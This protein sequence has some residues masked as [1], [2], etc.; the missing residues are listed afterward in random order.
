M[1]HAVLIVISTIITIIALFLIFI[2]IKSKN[3]RT[4]FYNFLFN[5]IFT[6]S[7]A[8]NNIIRLI[9][10]S[11]TSQVEASG[12]CK[13][14]A[15]ILTVL[16]KL[17]MIL[18]TDYSIISFLGMFKF[19]YYSANTKW[20]F[21]ILVSISSL[22][23]IILAI[24]FINIDVIDPKDEF[25]YVNTRN[26]VKI[27]VDSV[28][29]GLL[30]LI[31]LFCLVRI[32]FKLYKLKKEENISNEKGKGSFRL[33]FIRFSV[34]LTIIIILFIFLLLLITKNLS[35]L[36]IGKDIVYI[37][38]CLIVG[39]FFT[40]NTELLKEIKNTLKCSNNEDKTR[41]IEDS[42]SEEGPNN[43]SSD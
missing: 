38:L 3:F 11:D 39:L 30:F 21:I 28:V 16:D 18:I 7:I 14:Q 29:T 4:K 42:L 13:F 1:A 26:N 17:M 32:L 6:S 9:P 2:Y 19:E 41:S 8:L 36:D 23:S 34:N 24:I 25:C 10:A 37:I 5:I 15:F 31:N 33:H 27:S 40:I 12:A 43:P 22:L 35:F 20:L